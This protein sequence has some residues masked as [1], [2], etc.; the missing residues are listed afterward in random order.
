LKN[1][2][3]N[4]DLENIL[5][6]KDHDMTFFFIFLF[7]KLVSFFKMK[8]NLEWTEQ[9]RLSGAWQAKGKKLDGI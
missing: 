4:N 2:Q 5:S 9:K 7:S 1:F 8:K 6:G 3:I